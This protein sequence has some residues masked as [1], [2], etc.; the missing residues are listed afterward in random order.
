MRAVVLDAD[1][2]ARPGKCPEPTGDGRLVHV[3]ACGL[4]GSDVEKLGEA[5]RAGMVLGH[6]VAGE[7][8]DGTPVTVIHRVPCGRCERCLAGHGSTCAEFARLR[9]DPGGFAERLRA[10]QV[11]P[12]PAGLDELDGIWVEPLACILRAADH[13]PRGTV[14]VIGCGAIGQLWIQVLLRRGDDVFASDPRDDRLARAFGLGAAVNGVEVGAAVLTAHGG[15]EGALRH[16]APGGTLLV[17]ASPAPASLD[18]VYRSELRVVGS[19]SALPE[20]FTTA[21]ELLPSLTLPP[22]DV[23]PLDHFAEGVER[24]RS[25]AALKVAFAP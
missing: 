16:L 7:L 23:L 10:S 2:T 5:G 22:V 3:K 1:G 21:V 18:A 25:G 8:E 11:V 17:F 4:C 13:V 6:E 14:H 20:H 24:Y 9:I 12:L 19:R 15:L